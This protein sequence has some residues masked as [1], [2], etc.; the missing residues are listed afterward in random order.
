M[1]G[2]DSYSPRSKDDGDV[3]VIQ[4]AGGGGFLPEAL[5]PVRVGGEVGV[6]QLERDI[7][8]HLRVPR[9]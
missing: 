2:C 9:R 7:A 8:L 1:K 5:A 6:E 3:G 4:L